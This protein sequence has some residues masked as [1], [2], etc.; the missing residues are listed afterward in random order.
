MAATS[1]RVSAMLTIAL[2][3]RQ[4]L[5]VAGGRGAEFSPIQFFFEAVEGFVADFAALAHF[6]E[7]GAL[8]RDDLQL[9]LFVFGGGLRGFGAGDRERGGVGFARERRFLGLVVC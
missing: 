8:L 9:D 6:G 3:C 7:F 5:E 1:L 2:I 4:R